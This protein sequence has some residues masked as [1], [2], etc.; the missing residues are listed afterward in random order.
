MLLASAASA[1]TE[2][3]ATVKYVNDGDTVTLDSNIRV[4]LHGI[5]APEYNQAQGLQSKNYLKKLIAGKRVLI[6]PTDTD[7]YG[8]LVAK[9]YFGK[10]YVNRAI[11]LEGLA[12]WYKRYAPDDKDLSDAELDARRA[13]KG[14]WSEPVNPE[15]FRH[16][17][18]E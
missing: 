7:K 12:W 16:K 4:R 10:I 17:K 8:R 14:I 9:I 18:K 6:V 3:P 1:G 11:V 5:D 2:F 15:D 13:K